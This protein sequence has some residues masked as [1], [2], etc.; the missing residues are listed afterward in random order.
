MSPKK[1]TETYIQMGDRGKLST[2]NKL[3]ELTGKE[4]LKFSKSWFIHR[5]KSRKE[6]E[7]LHPAKFPESLVREFIEFFT[8]PEDLI[9]EPF[10]GTGSTLIAAQDANRSCLGIEVTKKYVETTRKRLNLNETMPGFSEALGYSDPILEVVHGDSHNL[11]ELA[12]KTSFK[13]KKFDFCV[14][15]PPYW[16]QLKRNSLRQAKRKDA[17]L[18][19]IYSD[20]EDDIGNIDD[21]EDFIKNQKKI[22]N[23]VYKLIKW[24]GY[25]VVITNNIYVGAGDEPD[26]IGKLYPLAYDTFKS[27]TSGSYK[28]IGKDEKIWLQDDKPLLSLGVN[29]AYIGNRHH[30]YCLVFRKE[31]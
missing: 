15:S 2:K 26:D 22:F 23:E 13:G 4:W 10:C 9:L 29:N 31:K 25:L 6:D 11:S 24:R 17:G 16:N 28:W 12:K 20:Q 5:P 21:Y 8:K 18:D 19:T 30:Q 3:N 1:N 7:I 14:T 27:L